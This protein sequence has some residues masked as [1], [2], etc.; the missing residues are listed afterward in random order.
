ML[1]GDEESGK[2]YFFMDKCLPF[3]AS[4]SCSHFQQFSNCVVFLCK[5]KT[6]R[7]TNNYLD[8]FILGALLE[9]LCNGQVQEFLKI[10][11]QIKF[12]VAPEKTV[13]EHR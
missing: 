8:D 13:W 3:G 5:N 6:G 12:P 11:D 7:S 2:I 4:I 10:C 9:A 1:V